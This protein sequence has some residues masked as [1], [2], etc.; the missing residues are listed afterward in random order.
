[1][2]ADVY[3]L[4]EITKQ[5]EISSSSSVPVVYAKV[6]SS[7]VGP[8][9]PG[10]HVREDARGARTRRPGRPRK[11]QVSYKPQY[12]KRLPRNGGDLLRGRWQEAD[13]GYFETEIL[14]RSK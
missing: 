14:S 3:S 4:D 7:L 1:V 5:Y 13:S 8:N 9:A 10:D 2:D 11:W 6:R 12:S